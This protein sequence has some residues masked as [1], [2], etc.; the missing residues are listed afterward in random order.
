MEVT[1]INKQKFIAELDKLLAFM[2]EEDREAAIAMYCDMFNEA[3]DEEA[4]I[5]QLV[6]PT[7]QAVIVARAYN[8]KERSIALGVRTAAAENN[9]EPE[10]ARSGE[11]PDYAKVICRIR[12]EVL[13]KQ[14]QL[15]EE[16][17]L[18]NQEPVTESIPPEETEQLEDVSSEDVPEQ[19]PVEPEG[20]ETEELPESD[21]AEPA[22]EVS[23]PREDA[24]EQEG[25]SEENTDN[26]V[27][28]IIDKALA[29]DEAADSNE[30]SE[31][32][33]EPTEYVRKPRVFLMILYI[34]AAIPV[35]LVGIVVMLI[36]ALIF[37]ALAAAAVGLGVFAVSCAFG[38]LSIFADIMIVVG[39][40]LVL[41]AI[42][43]LFLWTFIWF[44]GGA[45]A[46]FVR[47]I[48]HL[49][50]KWCYKE[51]AAE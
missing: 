50:G 22:Q 24:G 39:A 51:V 49:G 11:L 6:S 28:K 32:L 5:K 46:G 8:A 13:E 48:V 12:E 20:P 36:P 31:Q 14:R 1:Y 23:E 44:I 41:F 37:L 2:Y 17:Q 7:R 10:N 25:N 16:A 4:L 3:T 45:M 30:M 47:G 40:A 35:G 34:I 19:E 33:T 21:K 15:A 18:E 27:E 43:L 9:T 29:E 42:G 26:A 38:G